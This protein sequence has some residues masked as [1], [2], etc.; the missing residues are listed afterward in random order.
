MDMLT[1]NTNT[2]VGD[3]VITNISK[4]PP[5]KVQFQ[6]VGIDAIQVDI[7]G[8]GVI[9]YDG[10]SF[11]EFELMIHTNINN[12]L[13]KYSNLT[14]HNSAEIGYDFTL[15]PTKRFDR[16]LQNLIADLR[17][18]IVFK[19]P[20]KGANAYQLTPTIQLITSTILGEIFILPRNA[21]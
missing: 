14:G 18:N 13:K 19:K 9:D 5:I 6:E 11:D 1:S 4:H 20:V 12:H 3:F 10:T 21:F 16:E 7:T 15:T 2:N 8:T 17:L